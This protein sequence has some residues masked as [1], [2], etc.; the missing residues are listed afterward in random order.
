MK[1]TATSLLCFLLAA[2]A[3]GLPAGDKRSAAVCKE[4]GLLHP[5]VRIARADT[6]CVP[7]GQIAYGQTVTGQLDATD[8]L[9]PSDGS[10][11]DYWQFQGTTGDVVIIDLSS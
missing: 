5:G 9:L 4:L 11:V 10:Y 8:C 3:A 2:A 1:H 7:A 6:Q